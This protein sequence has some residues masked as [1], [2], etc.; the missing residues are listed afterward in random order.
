M[1]GAKVP[2]EAQVGA[3]RASA[4]LAAASADFHRSRD[5]GVHQAFCARAEALA[6][7]AAT[8]AWLRDNAEAVRAAARGNEQPQR[9]RRRFTELPLAQQAAL[10]CAEPLFQKF[11]RAET[12]DEAAR[13]LRS[14]CRVESRAELDAAPEAAAAWRRVDAEFQAWRRGEDVGEPK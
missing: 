11:M 10:R 9:E 14:V 2:I 13:A 6:A 7:A 3:V 1:A 8:L 12:Q 4:Q 5:A